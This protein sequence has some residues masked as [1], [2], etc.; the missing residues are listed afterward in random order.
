MLITDYNSKKFAVDTILVTNQGCQVKILG[1]VKGEKGVRYRI[2][3]LDK[4][5][6]ITDV[7][8]ESLTK[9]GSRNPYHRTVSKVGYIGVGKYSI[10]EHGR[11]YSIWSGM[12]CRCYSENKKDIDRIYDGC[13]VDSK[14]HN[15]QNF[16]KYFEER[17]VEGY[18]IDKDLL[19]DGNKIYGE[20]TC[21][22]LP[23]LVNIF[24]ATKK[25]GNKSGYVGVSFAKA[26]NKWK[27]YI[28]GFGTGK[29]INLGFFTDIEDASNAY[30]DARKIEVVKVK[31][32]MRDLGFSKEVYDK[33][34]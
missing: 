26:A 5:G 12:L 30:K 32:Y 33:I 14:W 6:F 3:F 28:C 29:T 18:Q 34:K 23:P 17:Y 25:A 19:V 16:A 15:F 27:A 1:K 20:D 31:A 9:G 24:L 10:K 22:F 8:G 4:H 7:R 13:Q 21:I 11:A 2:R